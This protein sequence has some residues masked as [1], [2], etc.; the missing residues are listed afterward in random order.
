MPHDIGYRFGHV[1]P[2]MGLCQHVV[3]GL[4]YGATTLD[5]HIIDGFLES[6]NLL[7]QWDYLCLHLLSCL[8]ACLI[9]RLH[10]VRY[11][12]VVSDPGL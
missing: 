9:D 7:L 12:S 10:L 1:L 11:L 6:H 4:I 2:L 3:V 5:V 8:E